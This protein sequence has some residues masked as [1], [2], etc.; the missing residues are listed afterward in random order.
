MISLKITLEVVSGFL[1][2]NANFADFSLN[3]LHA[4]VITIGPR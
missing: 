3:A 1:W 2:A 4:N